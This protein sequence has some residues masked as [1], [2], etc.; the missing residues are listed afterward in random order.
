VNRYAFARRLFSKQ[1]VIEE[2]KVIEEKVTSEGGSHNPFAASWLE[3]YEP[4]FGQM[5]NI[6]LATLMLGMGLRM[7]RDRG[8]HIDRETALKDQLEIAHKQI[9]AT[10]QHILE[11]LVSEDS[12][13]NWKREKQ[14]VSNWLQS[15]EAHQWI[16][17]SI[18]QSK[19]RVLEEMEQAVAFVNN[20]ND[21]DDN[22][23]SPSN[24]TT[25]KK[26]TV[27]F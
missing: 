3:R 14:S 13:S 7:V 12:I 16:K 4:H 18:E 1:R 20:D 10:E 2:A 19:M 24:T 11:S 27:L 6:V 5:L 25:S 26:K 17:E 9:K 8:D 15:K 22:E 21:D 23:G